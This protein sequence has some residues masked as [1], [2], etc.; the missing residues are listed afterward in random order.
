[1]KKIHVDILD[2]TNRR[3]FAFKWKKNWEKFTVGGL[4]E[5][6]EQ[7]WQSIHL[8]T[9]SDCTDN[10]ETLHMMEAGNT[11]EWKI[12]RFIFDSFVCPSMSAKAR[13]CNAK[14]DFSPRMFPSGMTKLGDASK[15]S[16]E[17]K[18]WRLPMDGVC[19]AQKIYLTRIIALSDSSKTVI[20]MDGRKIKRAPLDGKRGKM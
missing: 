16:S 7:H 6:A 13:C 1:M 17:R 14:G 5:S 10:K 2:V 20:E 3:I 8:K 18:K 11:F 9:Q 12:L 19:R 4:Q 15:G